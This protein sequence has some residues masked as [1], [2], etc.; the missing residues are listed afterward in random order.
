MIDKTKP[1]PGYGNS[2]EVVQSST[3]Y[4]TKYGTV[5]TQCSNNSRLLFTERLNKVRNGLFV[6]IGVW[7][8]ATLLSNYDL[9]KT[10]NIKIYGID[11]FEEISIFNGQSYDDTGKALADKCRDYARQRRINLEHIINSHN[12]S[13]NI[14]KENS[15]VAANSFEDNS[16]DLLH[17]DGDHSFD[18]VTK[19]LE[20]YFQKIK[21]GGCIINDDYNWPCCKSAIDQF[22]IRNQEAIVSSY[23]PIS[24]KH[25]IVKK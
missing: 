22:V 21:S 13:I 7:G 6:E 18:G 12:L 4:V 24:N 14:L 11:P 3:Q 9:C 10:N 19:D 23:S 17:I 1:N 16:I 8:G 15:A 5:A 20:L 25:L 2:L